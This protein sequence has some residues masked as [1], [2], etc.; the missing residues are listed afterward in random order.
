MKTTI[1]S[2]W[3]KH[4]LAPGE[5]YAGIITGKDGAPDHHVILLPG[6]AESVNWAQAKEFATKA[7][8]ELPTRREQAL[9]Y[10]NCKEDFQPNWYWSGEQHASYESYAWLQY[11][12]DGHQFNGHKGIKHR[13]R[14]VRRITIE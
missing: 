13:A 11:F 9:L 8:G 7:G 10:A 12:S 14:A 1:R 3:E 6:E 2:E 4:A 5:K